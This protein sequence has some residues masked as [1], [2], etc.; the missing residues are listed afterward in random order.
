MKERLPKTVKFTNV[1]YSF[2]IE[3]NNVG[4]LPQS[5]ATMLKLASYVP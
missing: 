5:S 1:L 3:Q 4:F 2:P